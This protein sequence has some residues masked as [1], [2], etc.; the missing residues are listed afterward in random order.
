VSLCEESERLFG[1]RAGRG[2]EFAHAAFEGKGRFEV[3]V[4]VDPLG[5]AVPERPGLLRSEAVG[6]DNLFVRAKIK[7][8]CTGRREGECEEKQ[9][10]SNNTLALFSSFCRSKKFIYAMIGS[11]ESTNFSTASVQIFDTVTILSGA[12]EQ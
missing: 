12:S 5:P 9:T 8:S 2:V 1:A 7:I 3:A 6:A 10:F 4:R 11:I